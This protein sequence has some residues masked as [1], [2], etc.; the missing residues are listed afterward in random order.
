MRNRY[1]R[2]TNRI[3]SIVMVLSMCLPSA[4]MQFSAAQEKTSGI[5]EGVVLNYR[6]VE[7]VDTSFANEPQDMMPVRGTLPSSYSASSNIPDS[8]VVE[9]MDDHVSPVKNQNPYGTC[10]AHAAMSIAE[11]SYIINENVASDA[12][13][14]NEYHLAHHAYDESTDT[15]NL[16]GGDSNANGSDNVSILDQGGNNLISLCVLASWQGA[17]DASQSIYGADHALNGVAPETI[18]GYGDTAHMENGYVLTMPDMSAENYQ[19][20]MDIIKQMIMEYGSVA[21]SYYA[22]EGGDGY[23]YEDQEVSTNHAVTVVGWSDD[24]PA[25]AFDNP[26]DPYDAPAPGNGAWLVK[27]SWNTWWGLGGYFWLSY[28]DTSI[29]SNAFVFDFVSGDNYDNN[30]QYDGTGYLYGS[31]NGYYEQV[32]GANVFV[33]DSAERIEAVG[34]YTDEVNSEYEIQIYRYVED[35]GAPNTG[36]LVHTQSGIETY[37]GFHTV[38]LNNSISVDEGEHYAVVVTLKKA[39]AYMFFPADMSSSW[40]WVEFNSFAKAGESY[41]GYDVNSL[42]DLNPSNT[43]YA[44]GTN[45]RIKAFTNEREP[46]E[47]IKVV[48]ITLDKTVA[49]M[50]MGD[51]L[52]LNARIT[53]GNATNAKVTWSTSNASIA[54]VNED[55]FV[56]GVAIGTAVITATAQ[57]GSGVSAS[58]TVTVT[59]KLVESLDI[60]YNGASIS[61]YSTNTIYVP[62]ENVIFDPIDFDVTVSPWN[63]SNQNVKWTS[64][65]PNVASVNEN[66]GVTPY[67]VGETTITVT[68]T[69]GSGISDS[70]T[71]KVASTLVK[72]I[73]I[74]YEGAVAEDRMT[75]SGVETLQLGTRISPS[76]ADNKTVLWSATYP[77]IATV[78]Q[79]GLVTFHDVGTAVIWVYAQDGSDASDYI[80]I[81]NEKVEEPENPIEDGLHQDEDGTWYY[82]LN[83]EIATEYT[84]LVQ[85][86]DAWFYVEN[87]VLNWNYTGLTLYNGIWFYVQGGQLNWG[88]TGLVQYYDAWFYV[89]GGVLNWDYTGLV[90]HYDAWFYVEGGQLNWGYTGL[91]SHNGIWFYVQN[92]QLNWNYTG[93]VQHYDAWFYVEGGQLNWSYTGLVQHYDAWFYVE[94]GQLNWGYTGLAQYAGA[95]FYV[96][97]GVLNW[98]YTGLVQHYDAWFYVEGGVLNWNYTGLAQYAGALFYVEGG[99]L[100]WN[101]T[102]LTFYNGA[103]YYVENG[104]AV[105]LVQTNS[106]NWHNIRTTC[107]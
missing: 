34:F 79:N 105:Y 96:E 16:F 39:G 68:A 74:T 20:D 48:S 23:Q 49:S 7:A 100:N 13:D 64:S 41:W 98:G 103:W 78:D 81:T 26:D 73:E 54:T 59:P 58:C 56:Q 101:Y 46:E 25:E 5:P 90:Q 71:F 57:D 91:V 94:G 77:E 12:L 30:Y 35:G 95:W 38:E 22:S 47:V 32:C 88:Y 63:A 80:L 36:T 10:W 50:M 89:E 43:D 3:L 9:K 76:N 62:S 70:I 67:A 19:T 75:V 42:R 15:L 24:I 92:G 27:N 66:G 104:I 53:P 99:V 86:Y 18:V 11:S 2:I 44:I 1:K 102:G 45:V 97:G 85:H 29:A 52:Q 84:G 87:G 65:N 14:L 8:I 69:D 83:G 31:T 17:S 107:L 60:T 33:A 51:S 93:L 55:G 82:Y 37:Y 106:N 6:E 28:Y 40:G 4:G 21:I 72:T 61:N